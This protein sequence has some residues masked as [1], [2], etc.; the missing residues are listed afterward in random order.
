MNSGLVSTLYVSRFCWFLG[1]RFS[2]DPK[3]FRARKA[4]CKTPIRLFCKAGL[5]RASRR[6]RFKETKRIVTRNAPEKFR[7]FR[8]MGLRNTGKARPYR[9]Q[10]FSS[11]ILFQKAGFYVSCFPHIWIDVTI[12][13]SIFSIFI[14]WSQQAS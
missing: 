13:P 11:S 2:N 12:N 5:F 7:D 10:S 9:T 8:E 14:E 3:T 4:I 6:L 1:T